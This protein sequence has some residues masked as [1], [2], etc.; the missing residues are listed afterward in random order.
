VFLLWVGVAACGTGALT[1]FL[2]IGFI[3][4]VS[5]FAIL[6]AAL[7]AILFVLRRRHAPGLVNR[8]DDM[9][10]GRECRAIAFKGASGRVQLGDGSWAARTVD[11]T[12]PP[13][14][15]LLWVVGREGTTLLVAPVAMPK[16][17]GATAV[18]D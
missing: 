1:E 6:L 11:G 17:R 13:A 2:G 8:P 10:L 4:Q 7:L 18:I 5:S 16:G 15:A 9:V 3:Y 14:D 12:T